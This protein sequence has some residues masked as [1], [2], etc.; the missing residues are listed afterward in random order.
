MNDFNRASGQ[1]RKLNYD[2]GLKEINNRY[3]QR[4]YDIAKQHG[5]K[6]YDP[7]QPSD[8]EFTK[9]GE[10]FNDMIDH[11]RQRQQEQPKQPEQKQE[12]SQDKEAEDISSKKTQEPYRQNPPKVEF[13]GMEQPTNKEQQSQEQKRAEFLEQIKKTREQQTQ[14]QQ[15]K[16]QEI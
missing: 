14:Q 4:A 10:K 1:N 11:A 12:T 9:Q 5:Y 3:S 2:D 6:G 7:N 13:K 15:D 8:K 16:Q